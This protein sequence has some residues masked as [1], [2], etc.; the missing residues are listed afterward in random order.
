MKI[1]AFSIG[2]RLALAF[3][4]LLAIQIAV[5]LVAYNA[6]GMMEETTAAQVNTQEVI[7]LIEKVKS[8][9]ID[10]ESEER[11]Y[12][13]TGNERYV[14]T[15][16]EGLSQIEIHFRQLRAIVQFKQ[17]LEQLDLMEPLV[18]TKLAFI[19]EVMEQ[20][21]QEGF[22]A[23]RQLV[24][25][26]RGKEAMDQ[27]LALIGK[28]LVGEYEL[29]AQRTEQAT[30]A[31]QTA[32]FTLIIGV[33]VAALVIVV[34]AVSISRSIASPLN[35]IATAAE[36]MAQGDLTVQLPLDARKDEIGVLS[37]AFH[38]MASTIR[39]STTDIAQAVTLLGSSA[40][41]IL[42]STT[43]VAAGTAETA[44]AINETTTTV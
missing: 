21:K 41:Q 10:V 30:A 14:A 16:Q 42:V 13:I 25:T 38:Q 27:I 29:L 33:L 11:A 3:G 2:N 7:R 5:G 32:R 12:L 15:Y 39:R 6:I 26:D 24:L 43:Q 18:A 44:S 22:E 19:S 28:I 4:V 9:L 35:R 17:T 36:Q 23:A 1:G 31:S 37:L 34:A 40:S 20:R 8:D